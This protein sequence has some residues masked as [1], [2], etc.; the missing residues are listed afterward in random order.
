MMKYN[1]IGS[2]SKGNCII[3]EDF[4]VLDVGVSYCKIKKYLSKIKLI[5]ISHSHSDHLNKTTIKQI[6]YNY[7]TIKFVTKSKEVL[8]ILNELKVKKQNLYYL[9]FYS[10]YNLGALKIKIEPLYHD[11]ENYALKFEI[12]DRKGLYVVDTNRID[13]IDA[14]NYD[15]YLIESNYQT[16]ILQKHIDEC[17]DKNQLMYLYRVFD[18]HL[19]KSDCDDFLINNMGEN[20]IFEYLHKSKY[21]NTEDGEY[22]VK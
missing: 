14:K 11:I 21:N 19:S 9:K 7:P 22:Y 6:V 10:W 13:H 4:L 1:I 16:D 15:L 2:S 8:S 17:D 12:N 18:T 3:V 5:F 20:S